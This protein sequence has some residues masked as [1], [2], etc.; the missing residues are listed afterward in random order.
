M[1]GGSNRMLNTGEA[2]EYI[3]IGYKTFLNNWRRWGLKG[4]RV[5][6]RVMFRERDLEEWLD[7]QVIPA[8]DV[9]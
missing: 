9:A 3:G 7:K 5:G 1:L 6:R 4:R 2:A 8:L